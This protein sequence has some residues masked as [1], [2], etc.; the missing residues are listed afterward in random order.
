M[1]LA[2]TFLL[3]ALPQ[4]FPGGDLKLPPQQKTAAASPE[5]R[6]LNELERFRRDLLDLSG[7]RVRIERK[8]EDMGRAYPKIEELI[9]QVARS[10]RK[11]EMRRLMVVARRFGRTS[12]TDRV[13]DELLFQLLARRLGAATAPVVETM[14]IL[15]GSGAKAALKQCVRGRNAAVR[16]QSAR[17]LA[18][19]CTVE[20]DLPFAMSLSRE[21]SLD[22]RLRGVD[23][24]RAI[25]GEAASVRLVEL[26]SKDPAL[27]AASCKALI[28]VGAP[29]VAALQSHLERPAVDRSFAY[30]AFAL[31]QIDAANGG[32]KPSLPS[33]LLEPLKRQLRAPEALTQVLAAV[34]LADLAYRAAPSDEPGEWAELDARLVDAL[35]LVVEPE[36]FVP[37]LDMLRAPAEQRLLRHTG[38][39]VTG[40]AGLSWREWW[41]M[42]RGT[43]L[44]VRARIEVSLASAATAIVVLRTPLL[45]GDARGFGGAPADH[46]MV[47]LLGD[48]LVDL[49]PRQG[50]LD[51]VLPAERMLALV[52]SFEQSGFGDPV[53]MQVESA[54]PRVRSLELRLAG[55]RSSV[56]VPEQPHPAFDRMAAEVRAVVDEQLWQLYRPSGEAGGASRV[57]WW[58]TESAWR[59][60]HS[61]A[62]EQDR[63]FVDQVVVGWGEWRDERKARAI[64]F[65][66]GHA[67]RKELL[68]AEQGMAMVAA[69]QSQKELDAYDRGLLEFAA[70]VPGEQVWRDCVALA[71]SF[72]D[73]KREI[74]RGVFRVLGPDAVLEALRDER[75]VVQRAAVDEAVAS[76]DLRAGPTLVE[77]LSGEDFDLAIA[78]AY[79][80]GQLRVADAQKPLVARIVA[81]E[82]D[83][84]LRRECLRALGRVGGRM[85]FQVLERAMTAPAL[86]DKQAAMRGLGELRDPRAAHLLVELAVVGHGQ[87]LGELAQFHLQRHG[88]GRAVPALERQI[89]LCKNEVIRSDLVMLLGLYQEPSNVSALMDL[90]RVPKLAG[91][92]AMRLE[93]TTGVDLT[94]APDRITAI[95]NWW[96]LHKEEAQW[97]WL[98]GALEQAEV[99]H[100]LSEDDLVA[101]SPAALPELARLMVEAEQPRLWT[102]AAAV[103]RRRLDEDYGLV[104]Y[105]TPIEVREGLAGRY[106]LLIDSQLRAEGA[107][108]A[109][110]AGSDGGR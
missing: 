7:P 51:V 42:Q 5:V 43:F 30:A 28:G 68:R 44:G 104:T 90:L 94:N 78:A 72:E 82:T 73:P 49:P 108:R 105:Q 100:R 65:L 71:T 67:R 77:M 63:R 3:A 89:P 98:L 75:A 79:A 85:A 80:C 87:Q 29:S 96:R 88:R 18:P 23:L 93:E 47:R 21:Q 91:M 110:N 1:T 107:G 25:G 74:V 56:A 97:R 33:E 36:A 86:E 45:T 102:L 58:R 11:T 32:A 53:A 14:A 99:R 92:A 31:A 40:V 48:E 59:A 22:L 13:A 20:E 76:R 15:K 39:V 17:V 19:L 10:A 6:P 84:V 27:A 106:Q 34:P 50:S 9:L 4:V 69:L 81:D 95:E 103:L 62:L 16:R 8:L 109:G 64:R 2:A 35:L 66:A 12:G 60:Q 83:P 24:L 37:N 54:L 46:R 38:R 26:L 52:G 55:G 101:K 61:D 70:G 41:Q 57:S